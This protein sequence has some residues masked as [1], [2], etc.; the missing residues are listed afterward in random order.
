[1]VGWFAFVTAGSTLNG[2][3]LIEMLPDEAIQLR[4]SGCIGCDGRKGDIL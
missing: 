1:M 3:N 2:G 4:R